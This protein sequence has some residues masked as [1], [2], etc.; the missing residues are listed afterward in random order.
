YY[1]RVRSLNGQCWGN[2]SPDRNFRIA[3]A[4][5]AA[6]S[7]S[8][9]ADGAL[10]VPVSTTLSWTGDVCSDSYHLEVSP[11]AGFSV[12]AAD[13]NLNV[14][15]S[16][17]GP[18]FDDTVYYWRVTA[19]NANFTGSASAVRSFR[20]ALAP[21]PAPTLLSPAAGASVTIPPPAFV[22]S[23]SRKVTSYRFE[24]S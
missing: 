23:S 5:P 7:L 11:D 9:P 19:M 15:S 22:W 3:L 13:Q 12:L 2:F 10:N 21:P 20:T 18:L 24:V 17:I 8:L 1:W 14:T 16:A 4:T 6:P